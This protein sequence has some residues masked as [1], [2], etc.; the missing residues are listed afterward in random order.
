MLPT[1][2]PGRNVITVEGDALTAGSKLQVEY[3]WMEGT[4]SKART[5]IVTKLPHVYEIVVDEKDPLK[6]RCLYQTLTVV[7]R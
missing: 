2:L 4:A 5:E 7:D 1:L 6:V 3:A